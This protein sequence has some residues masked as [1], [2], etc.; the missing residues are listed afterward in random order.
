MNLGSGVISAFRTSDT[1]TAAR[2]RYEAWATANKDGAPY[3][4][5]DDI[6]TLLSARILPNIIGNGSN[7]VAIIV[8]ISMIS[9]TA[10]GGYF[11]IRKR[12]EQ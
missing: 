2:A 12:R 8:I 9:V 1:F 4:G 3:D 11:F 10:I 5:N 6:Q 7:T